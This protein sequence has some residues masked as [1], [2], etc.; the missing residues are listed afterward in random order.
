MNKFWTLLV[1][2]VACGSL[3]VGAAVANPPG[4]SPGKA[5]AVTG[6]KTGAKAVTKSKTAKKVKVKKHTKKTV[7]K[8][9]AVAKKKPVVK[10]G[11]AK[12]KKA[13]PAKGTTKPETAK[14]K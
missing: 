14:T 11:S 6:V 1:A 13:P 8:K 10:A 2:T 12:V 5:K 4:K 3:L 9:H 7:S